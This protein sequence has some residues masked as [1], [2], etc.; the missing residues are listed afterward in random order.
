MLTIVSITK[1]DPVGI[2]ATLKSTETL[3]SFP[4]VTHIIV[5]SS[6]E[7][8]RKTVEA[9][10]SSSNAVYLWQQPS[11]ISSA[12]N[13][14]LSHSAA[15]WVWFLNG[16]DQAHP[17]LEPDKL[18]YLL[19]TGNADLMIF[20]MEAKQSRV[21]VKHPPFC[22]LWPPALNWI[23]HP[24]TIV[25]RSLFEQFGRF[26]EQY[27]I[28]MDFDFWLRILTK[29]V[30]ADVISLPITLFDESGVS[31]V[32]RPQ[33]ARE[34]VRVLKGYVFRLLVLWLLSGKKIFDA[35]RHYRKEGKS[36]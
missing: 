2:L 22:T 25:R 27:R 19:K 30:V 7:G 35:L 11:G 20:Q 33:T 18:L 17:D 32:A 21:R 34:S 4:G 14:G 5:D 36:A 10:V 12:F 6:D 15:E 28:A 29:Y 16:G 24:S 13:L 1:D 3:R 8:N 26:D 23:P 9:A 31:S